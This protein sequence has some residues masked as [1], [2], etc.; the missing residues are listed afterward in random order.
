MGP[1]LLSLSEKYHQSHLYHI[2]GDYYVF[3]KQY[4]TAKEYYLQSLSISDNA[5]E[6]SI[7][8]NKISQ[9]PK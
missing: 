5:T 9:I 7:I 3:L 4:P 2:L 8:T 1:K 6:Q